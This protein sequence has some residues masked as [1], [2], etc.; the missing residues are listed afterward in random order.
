MRQA[1]ERLGGYSKSQ[2]LGQSL[3]RDPV[4]SDYNISPLLSLGELESWQTA[5]GPKAGQ[6]K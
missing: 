4:S 6:Q 2:A 3:I 5:G 1:L